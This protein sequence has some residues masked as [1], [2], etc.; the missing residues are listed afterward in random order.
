M[1]YVNTLSSNLHLYGGRFVG[2]NSTFELNEEELKDSQV[3]DVIQKKLIFLAP[4][5]K[6]EKP[7]KEIIKPNITPVIDEQAFSDEIVQTPTEVLNVEAIHDE[8]ND[9]QTPVEEPVKASVG[10]TI[11]LTEM[12]ADSSKPKAKINPKK[13]STKS[14]NEYGPIEDDKEAT[15]PTHTI[16]GG[17]NHLD[18]DNHAKTQSVEAN[19]L[20]LGVV[21][22]PNA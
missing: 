3:Q 6:Q 2:P 18:V 15:A 22:P 9:E 11:I 7:N 1:K 14:D 4:A 19:I 8:I 5:K 16:A 17:Q 12:E 10:E 13:K 21:A 20:Q